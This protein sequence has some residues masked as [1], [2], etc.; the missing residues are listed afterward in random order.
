MKLTIGTMNFSAAVTLILFAALSSFAEEKDHLLVDEKSKA[1][2][3]GIYIVKTVE[4]TRNGDGE[5]VKSNLED[6]VSS[7]QSPSDLSV[8]EGN[9]KR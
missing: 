4:G 3:E 6:A 5:S 8:E 7:D 2:D 9:S 1:K